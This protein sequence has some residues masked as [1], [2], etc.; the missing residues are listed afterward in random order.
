MG[1]P[2]LASG[3]RFWCRGAQA[4]RTSA[5][6]IRPAACASSSSGR[7]RRPV[8]GSGIPGSRR[9]AKRAPGSRGRIYQDLFELSARLPELQD[10]IASLA[11][12]RALRR[13]GPDVSHLEEILESNFAAIQ[14]YLDSVWVEQLVTLRS[15][16][17][18]ALELYLH[19]VVPVSLNGFHAKLARRF[20]VLNTDA[21]A[22]LRL[23]DASTGDP[24]AALLRMDGVDF[25]VGRIVAPMPGGLFGF[26]T[27]RM[28]FV[29]E[30]THPALLARVAERLEPRLTHGVSGQ[31]VPRDHVVSSSSIRDP[32]YGL[33]S[34]ETLDKFLAA[35]P[36]RIR[37]VDG[38]PDGIVAD[39]RARTIALEAGAYVMS[40]DLILP[41][42]FGL[43]LDAG[44]EL[45]IAPR[46][47]MLVRGPLLVRGSSDRP[48]RMRGLS[49]GEPWGVLAAQGKGSG[50]FAA[51]REGLRSEIR[52]LELE[53]GSEDYLRGAHYKGQLSVYN[54]DLVLEHSALRRSHA[55]DSLNVTYGRVFVSD[56]RFTGSRADGIDL[57]WCDGT[58]RRSFFSGAGS[59]GDG[60]DVSGSRVVV[61]DSVFSQIADKCLS[62]GENSRMKVS[63][64][65]LR[66]C[67]IGVA[68][69]DLSLTEIRESLFID[70]QRDFAAY[71][72]KEIFGGG[73][74]RGEELILANT[75]LGA[76]RD[77]RSEIAISHSVLIDAQAGDLKQSESVALSSDEAA[78]AVDPEALRTTA[79]F[80]RERFRSI[81]A[82]LP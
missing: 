49:A 58:V 35:L 52:H 72:K 12:S 63:G 46:K 23:I 80:S 13:F 36:R 43:T 29:L 18:A 3:K 15:P 70:N 67:K 55:D 27:V 62:V 11:N 65:L 40:D 31:A 8:A 34:E 17:E 9:I 53:G 59:G 45:R 78:A 51:A 69:K 14:G 22:S 20:V 73:R 76:E 68:S 25:P 41:N 26:Q 71:R 54:Q 66:G 21:F 37:R 7:E 2:S 47:S 81:R 64:S 24:H 10:S 30:A 42:G 39:R 5:R 56:S 28:D 38:E 4:P 61:E 44:V 75:K 48:V 33:G 16:T 32:R 79:T 60:L 77:H 82:G 50:V 1:R 57:D 19:S 6:A 74:I